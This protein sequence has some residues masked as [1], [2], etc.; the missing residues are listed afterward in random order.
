LIQVTLAAYDE[1]MKVKYP[2]LIF[3]LWLL[4]AGSAFA[5]IVE[6]TFTGVNGV[7]AFGYYVGPYYGTLG[8]KPDTLYC[9]DFANEVHSGQTWLA[10]LTPLSSGDLSNTRYG[11]LP[12][13]QKLYWEAAWLTTQYASNTDAYADIQATIWQLFVPTAP[14]PGSNKWLN[15]AAANY[16]SIDP[17]NFMVVTNVSP[18]YLKGEGQVQEFIVDPLPVPEPSS[19]VL[20]GMSVLLVVFCLR[21]RLSATL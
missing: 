8:G 15:L 9:D 1:F 21:R 13:A 10:N 6:V 19:I 17:K 14:A 2:L 3:I 18:V 4:G 12:G 11:G 16:T 7:A 20:L 5:D